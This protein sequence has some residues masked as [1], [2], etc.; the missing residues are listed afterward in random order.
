MASTAS[1]EI[2]GVTQNSKVKPWKGKCCYRC[3]HASGKKRKCKCRCG[4]KLHGKAHA[5]RQSMKIGEI[6]CQGGY[7]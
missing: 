1:M 2:N 6:V 5:D 7:D 4:G 3:Y